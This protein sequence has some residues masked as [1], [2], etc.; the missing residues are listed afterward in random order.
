LTA[1]TNSSVISNDK[2]DVSIATK[3]YAVYEPS[4]SFKL[5]EF[6]R[7]ISKSTDVLIRIY[8]C[9]IC[10]T[11]IHMALN[12][13][14]YS[15][16]PIVPG[17]E[18]TGVVEQI[19]D[20]VKK[21]QVGD[22]VGVGYMINSCRTCHLCKRDLEQYCTNKCNT[23]NGTQIGQVTPT[24]GGYSNFIVV[25]E[26]FVSKIPKNLPL[27]SA[28]PLLCAGIST[29]SSL[30]YYNVGKNTRLGIIG[31]GGLGHIAIKLGSAMGAYVI[32][33][34]SSESK[35]N[36]ALKLGANE[37]IVSKDEKQMKQIKNSLDL[38]LDTVSAPHD[39]AS[40]IDLL[41]FEG[42]YTIIGAPSKSLEI[43]TF[44]LLMKR[45]IISG[46]AVGGMK[47]TQEMLDFCGQHQITCDIE[48]IKA[49]P[50]AIKTAFDRVIK[51]DIKYRFVLDIINA[52]K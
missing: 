12:Q 25:D 47:E 48:L 18:I 20:N 34:S 37:F 43:P 8:Y 51:A 22:H 31:L 23:S 1:N 27:D 40:L 13:W 32:V 35:R 2:C 52:F 17:H 41:R 10:H 38:I 7:H 4:D 50:E 44:P 45:P 15:K 3:A 26:H 21:F 6:E 36:D 33:I 5:F 42:V 49:T 39:V 30:R 11:D 16:Y 14:G 28:A 29:Y 9:G 19:G 46:S 24:Y